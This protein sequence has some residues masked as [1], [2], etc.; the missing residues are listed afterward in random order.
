MR[1][2]ASS[3]IRPDATTP[4]LPLAAEA[5]EPDLGPAPASA[6]VVAVPGAVPRHDLL[7]GDI[8]SAVFW[9]ALPVLGEQLLNAMVAWND[10]L[11][12]GRIDAVATAAVGFGAYVSWLVS[13]L[14]SLAG[15]GATAIVARHVGERRPRRA[16][17][18]CNQ[19][20]LLSIVVGA[21]GMAAVWFAVGPM[22]RGLGLSAAAAPIAIT[23]IRIDA[24]GYVPESFLFVGAACLRGA[25]DTRTPL[26]LIGAVQVINALASWALTFGF[27]P[28]PAI[29]TPGIAVGTTVA[30][31]VAGVMTLIVLLR[32]RHGLRLSAPHFQPDLRAIER[33]VRIGLPAA[34]DGGLMWGGHFAFMAILTRSALRGADYSGDVLY[35]AHIVGIRIESLSYMP[36]WAWG[37][38]ASTLVGQNLGAGQ[39][40][41]ALRCAREARRQALWALLVPAA[42]FLLAARPAYQLLTN[43]PRVVE[44]GV[45][46][47]RALAFLQPFVATLIVYLGALRGAGDTLVPMSFTLVGMFAV[48]VPLAYFGGVVFQGGLLGA[49]AGMFADLVLRSVLMNRR[50]RSGRWAKKRI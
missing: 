44:C 46:A 26:K 43:D 40:H 32:G 22:V 45:P 38:A 50:L 14:F 17:H 7:R 8:R 37:L 18:A 28:I 29:G 12:A 9:L 30:R 39:R 33:I 42:L 21:V 11:L 13:M 20:L 16:N 19:A 1:D 25:G 49:W 48:R 36:A 47:L 41:R 3:E 24:I 2:D 10:T 4:L 5:S 34:V 15:I 35:A 27:G 6:E 31:A 23:Y